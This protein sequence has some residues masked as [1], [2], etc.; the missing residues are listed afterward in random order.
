MTDRSV[1]SQR[2]FAALEPALGKHTAERA[3]ELV[4]K[5]TGVSA[6]ELGPADIESVRAVLGPMLRTLLGRAK[7]E[8]LLAKLM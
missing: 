8:Q 7:T 3:L 4:C 1:L 2:V 5:K 6:S